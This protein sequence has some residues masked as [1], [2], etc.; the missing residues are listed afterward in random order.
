MILRC[1]MA[2]SRPSPPKRIVVQVFTL[3]FTPDH[4]SIG[5]GHT[6][7]WWNQVESN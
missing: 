2:K 3:I 6:A 1:S 7:V 4:S 5:W